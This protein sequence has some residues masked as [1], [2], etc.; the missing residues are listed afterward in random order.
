MNTSPPSLAEHQPIMKKKISLT[1]A[2]SATG[3]TKDLKF[4]GQFGTLHSAT[5]WVGTECR[6][7]N[8]KVRIGVGKYKDK[9]LSW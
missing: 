7:V 5:S 8:A 9:V 4:S 2:P 6:C 1:K 3:N